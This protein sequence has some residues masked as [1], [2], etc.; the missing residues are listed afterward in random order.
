MPGI[1]LIRSIAFLKRPEQGRAEVMVRL[2]DGSFSSFVVSTPSQPGAALKAEG[3]EF[4][5]GTPVL[6]AANIDEAAIGEA[7]SAMAADI[8]GFWLR[9]Y[10]TLGAKKKA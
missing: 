9:Y 2:E 6:F 7:V 5:F 10:N 1:P 8:G 3:R 4:L